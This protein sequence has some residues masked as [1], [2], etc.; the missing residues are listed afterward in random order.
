VWVENLTSITMKNK[1]TKNVLL[2]AMLLGSAVFTS[3]AQVTIFSENFN[4]SSPFPDG[5]SLI[6]NG[7]TFGDT[8]SFS[9][10]QVPGAG[11]GG[12]GAAQL[13]LNAAS[14]SD[15]YS[16]ASVVW[17]S[18]G[19]SLLSGNTS[20]NLSDYTLSFYAQ[21]N[22]G[23]LALNLQSWSGEYATYQG[24]M[25]TIPVV[26]GYGNDLTLNSGY[27]YYSLNLGN[28]SIFP[29]EGSFQ[30]NGGAIQITFQLDG[31]G[32]TPYSDTLDISDLQLTM[33]PEPASTS[34]C[35][36]G[37]LAAF[38]FLRRRKN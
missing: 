31:G 8:T 25:S 32:P 34:L 26:P 21:A 20:A 4:T 33:V 9:Y 17:A 22:A 1:T 28:A 19:G 29:T 30:P 6:N 35:S 27:T 37:G 23:S 38:A 24:Q 18:S 12:N 7:D 11:V 36:L 14:G 13:V 3:Q 16:G 10:G 2:A 15:G 5:S